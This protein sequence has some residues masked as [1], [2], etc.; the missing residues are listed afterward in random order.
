M[1][2]NPKRNQ[3]AE[4]Q[5]KITSVKTTEDVVDSNNFNLSGQQITWNDPSNPQWYEQFIKVMNAALPANGVFGKPAKKAT[6]NGVPHEQYRFNGINTDIPKYSFQKTVEGQSLPFEV[7]STDIE[8]SKLIEEIPI[9]G[10][11]FACLYKNDGQ[12][13]ASTNTGFFTTFKQG[14]IDEGQFSVQNP[15]SNQKIDIDATDINDKDVWLFKLDENGRETEYWTKVASVE[16][17]NVIYNSLNKNIRNLYSVLTRVNDRISLIFSDGVFGDLPKGRFKVVYRT[18]ANKRYTIKPSEMSNIQISIPYLSAVGVPETLSL[19]MQLKYT[20]SNSALSETNASIKANAPSTYYT[21]NRMVTAEDYNVAPLAVS[22]EIVKVKTVNRNA[23]GISRYFDLIDSTGKYSSTN[24]FGNDGVVYKETANLKTNFNFVTTTDIEQAITNTIEPII[25]DRKVYNYY[26]ENF[27]KILAADLGVEWTSSTQDT[28]RSTGYINDANGT[29]FKV[30]GFTANNLRFL[31]AGTL[32]KFVAPTG[33]HFMTTNKNNLMSGTANHPGAV[34]YIWT[35]VISVSGDGT[36]VGS[37]GLGP[38]VL[39]DLI[40]TGAIVQEVRP[41]LANVITDAVKTQIVDQAFATNTFGLRYDVETRQWRIITEAN[42]D[43]VSNFSTGK[44]GDSSNQNLDASWIMYFKTDGERYDIT[45]RTMRYVFES[46]KEIK[47]YYDSTDK[48]YDN[49]TGKVIK[50]KIEV[51]NINNKPDVSDPFTV[52]Y[53]WE[54]VKEYRDAEGYVDSKRIEVSFFD[55]DDDGIIDNPQG[56]DDIV[57]ESTNPETKYVFQKKYTTSDGVEDYRYVDNTVEGIQVKANIGAIGAYSAYNAGQVFFT[58]DTELFH[59]L[60]ATKKNLSIIKDYRGYIGRAGLKFRYLHSADY[61]QRLDPAASNIM[62]CYLLTRTYDIAYRQWL[63]G[64]LTTEPLPPSSDSMYRAY[65][66]ELDK[67]KSISDEIIYHPVKYKALFGTTAETSLQATF[68][69]VTNPDIVVNNNDIK[70]RV[71]E[72]INTYFSLENWE[73]GESFYFSELSTYIMNQMAPDIVS[74]VIV[75]NEQS[76]SF[77][78]LYEIKS[79]SNEIFISSATVENV[80]IIDAI[81]AGR[82]RATGNVVTASQE[83]INTGVTST[84]SVPST[85]AM[86][87]TSSSSSSSRSSSS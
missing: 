2:Y 29:R 78:S 23:S 7:V 80:E 84:A 32:V 16:G 15:S 25:R 17:N 50:D 1:S 46:D 26:L 47:F 35:K 22:Q 58:M 36:V 59:K 28:N 44:T 39:N 43:S 53:D 4:G 55:A 54:V 77:G 67:I 65:G 79:E 27:T 31:E 30:A 57:D 83:T 45:Y 9:V 34:D 68:K 69:V 33:F 70:S 40:P 37:T 11:S 20:V 82:L 14:F 12:G 56:F 76:Q 74:I 38:I 85:G 61:N 52:S 63:Q 64:D 5:L 72:A 71:I 24:L 42:L 6:I 10:N 13:P 60:D 41:K 19:T 8:E 75:P 62:D 81:T 73:F 48:I 3:A 87:T 51:L 86:T 66:E 21:Q 18:S 49:K